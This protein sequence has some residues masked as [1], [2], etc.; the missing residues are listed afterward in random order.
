MVHI[1]Y[2]FHR[3]RIDCV[4][5]PTN[6]WLS[7]KGMGKNNSDLEAVSDYLETQVIMNVETGLTM[8]Q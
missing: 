4:D 7:H 2:F 3:N 8:L 5:E 1:T 6:I